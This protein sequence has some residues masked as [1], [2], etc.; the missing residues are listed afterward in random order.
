MLV[1]MTGDEIK[2]LRRALDL[3]ARKLGEALGVD[4]ATVLAW[5]REELFPT[6][7]YVEAMRALVDEGGRERSPLQVLADPGVWRLFRKIV[8]H[9][10]LRAE[11]ERAAAKY[12][13][14]AED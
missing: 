11:V 2:A 8:A 10:A 5:E 4:Q 14:P 9:P 12:A 1:D 13:D 6:K 3:T 7:Q